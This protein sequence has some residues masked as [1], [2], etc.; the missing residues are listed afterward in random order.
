MAATTR[1]YV[2]CAPG[3]APLADALISSLAGWGV[4][5]ASDPRAADSVLVVT[6]PE[7]LASPVCIDDIRF[8]AEC[9]YTM[10]KSV[11]GA[12]RLV[13]V[14]AAPEHLLAAA[15]GTLDSSFHTLG[16]ARVPLPF[17][18]HSLTR[19]LLDDLAALLGGRPRP[20]P[21]DGC[22]GGGPG[23]GPPR[24]SLLALVAAVL[25]VLSG[26]ITLAALAASASCGLSPAVSFDQVA[27][28]GP[29]TYALV[30]TYCVATGV[31]AGVLLCNRTVTGPCA[32]L[33]QDRWGAAP[34]YTRPY[35]ADPAVRAFFA[36]GVQER[37]ARLAAADV[38]A[39]LVLL[40]AST[41]PLCVLLFPLWF[42]RTVPL[43]ACARMGAR[44][45]RHFFAAGVLLML[46][47][48]AAC[49]SAADGYISV[50]T[51]PAAR[52]WESVKP[53]SGPGAG[54][55]Q[56]AVVNVGVSL[57]SDL[58]GAIV[59]AIFALLSVCCAAGACL[60]GSSTAY[61]SV[62][63]VELLRSM[64]VAFD[65][66]A[67]AAAAAVTA[68]QGRIRPL[69]SAAPTAGTVGVGKGE[70]VDAQQQRPQ[71]NGWDG[72]QGIGL[73]MM[74][75][76]ADAHGAAPAGYAQWQTPAG[77][78][79]MVLNP[80]RVMPG[81][82]MMP[83]LQPFPQPQPLQPWGDPPSLSA[84][85]FPDTGGRPRVRAFLSH[86]WNS[87]AFVQA[88]DATLQSLGVD[89][90]VDQ[91]AMAPGDEM[92]REIMEGI[93]VCDVFVGVRRLRR[94]RHARLPRQPQL[95]EG[96]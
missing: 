73:P 22:G 96:G 39:A 91:T 23:S 5:R 19:A 95:H 35:S 75:P 89:T 94:L 3:D 2:S 54:L 69:T 90:W 47:G 16:R 53:P 38:P 25:V 50:T 42:G 65:A 51:T 71:L 56:G 43:Y 76:H 13:S 68:K 31:T 26:A 74:N 21:A 1:V 85:A 86:Q 72:G 70:V 59:G 62:R 11:A 67:A 44:W 55:P 79:M 45:P 48:A 34:W 78:D 32:P 27:S 33:P 82:A 36:G 15:E 88:V 63:G 80:A 93:E 61:A 9:L 49:A 64:G 20:P 17:R 52:A 18:E 66:E 30:D 8:A 10:R 84:A 6:T 4:V 81:A 12:E 7:S 46:A 92:Y 40:L 14:R 57:G 29:A 83:P 24:S 87:K 58:A 60:C 28:K 77:P 41:V 37:A